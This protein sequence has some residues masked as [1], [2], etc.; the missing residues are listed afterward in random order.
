MSQEFVIIKS[1]PHGIR[2]LLDEEAD[3]QEIINEVAEKFFKAKDFFGNAEFVLSVKGRE[4]SE[5]EEYVLI[6][7]IQRNSYIRV[8]CISSDDREQDK[9][10]IHA[11]QVLQSRLK[12]ENAAAFYY[13]T[14]CDEEDLSFEDSVIIIGD[15]NPGC[16]V[17][18]NGSVIVM[19]RLFGTVIAGLNQEPTA[20][21]AAL[22]FSP[23]HIE[24]AYA[25]YE[26]VAKH[27]WG[28]KPK[29]SPKAA[30]ISERNVIEIAELST[31]S[32]EKIYGF[33]Q[34]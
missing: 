34:S 24:I 12:G 32:L 8:L 15:V 27:R 14:V 11:I 13:G 1:F 17:R 7:T 22:E 18:S 9:P 3:Y 21:V 31:C 28:I 26:P 19:G 30:Y 25:D 10:Y 5:E 6:E 16:I 2:I 29:I 4:L 23:E 20:L 33:T